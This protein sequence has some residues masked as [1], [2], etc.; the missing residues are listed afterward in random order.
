MYYPLFINL[1]NKKILIIG[2][3]KVGS[4]RALYLLKAGA[5]V[6]V[7]SKEFDKKL[8][9]KNKHLKIIKKEINEKN[10]NEISLKNYFLVITATN[11]KKINEK[12]TNKTKK[13]NKTLKNKL[14]VCRADKP[15]D[16]DVI[17]PAVS[18][19]KEVKIA[20]TSFGKNP[21]L[22]KRIKGIIENEA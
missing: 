1:K 19:V 11:D 3:G 17:F 13:I 6:T 14:L 15:S 22:I 2:G 8:E 9:T 4:R 10:L 20:Y 16:G 12:I 5:L 18:D 7:I 21:R